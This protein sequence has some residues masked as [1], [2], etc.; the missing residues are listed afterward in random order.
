MC[1]LQELLRHVPGDAEFA[2]GAQRLL[3]RLC[4]P[5]YLDARPDCLGLVKNAQTGDGLGRA[6]NKYTA[7]GDYYL[8]EALAR[9]LKVVDTLW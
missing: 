7:W 6:V 3:G 8:M 2:A 4:M 5:D 9:E 1:G